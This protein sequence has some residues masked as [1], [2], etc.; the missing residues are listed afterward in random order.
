[1]KSLK[2]YFSSILAMLIMTGCAGLL[3]PRDVVLPLDRLQASLEQRFPLNQRYLELFDVHISHP[4]LNLQPGTNRVVTSVDAQIL[5]LLFGNGWSGSI[6]VSGE[7]KIDASRNAV[8]L[9]EPRVE[10]LLLD[11]IDPRFSDRLGRFGALLVEQILRDVPLYSFRAEDFRTAGTAFIP[12]TIRTRAD[13]LV[14]S[15]AP[16]N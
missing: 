2:T 4:R 15:F 11:G 6:S 1:M 13:A 14:V 16:A 10:R 8:L 5:P 7:L 12:V 9:A 3:G